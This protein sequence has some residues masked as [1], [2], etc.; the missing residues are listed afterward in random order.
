MPAPTYPNTGNGTLPIE[1]E[2][3]RAFYPTCKGTAQWY[4]TVLNQR[5]GERG[6]IQV[7]DIV[8]QNTENARSTYNVI[9]PVDHP[10]NTKAPKGFKPIDFDSSTDLTSTPNAYP[11]PALYGGTNDREKPLRMAPRCANE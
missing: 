11:G 5:A 7:G 10:K 1:A 8:L 6:G 2:F 4:A 9:L 3:L